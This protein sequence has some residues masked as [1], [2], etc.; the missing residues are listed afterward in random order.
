MKPGDFEMREMLER[1][2]LEA[3]PLWAPFRDEDRSVI[4]AWGIP[5]A[6]IDAE[7]QRYD[8]CG[9][10]PLF[11]V[12][13]TARV[14][15]RP[16]FIVAARVTLR[17]G[18]ELPGYRL[19]P[20]VVGVFADDREWV[21]NAGLSGRSKAVASSLADVLRMPFDRIFPLHF[22]TLVPGADGRPLEGAFAPEER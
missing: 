13:D 15:D 11:P 7:L 6:R 14:P 19:A 20:W 16:D 8:Y 3:H 17:D 18:R 10:E 9:L 5:E 4:L 12:L 21:F 22:R 1:E 2:D